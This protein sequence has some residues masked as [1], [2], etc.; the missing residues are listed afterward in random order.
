MHT[1]KTVFSQMYEHCVRNRYHTFVT[2]DSTELNLL[3]FP[4]VMSS[5]SAKA[6]HTDCIITFGVTHLWPKYKKIFW[7]KFD[8]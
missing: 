8:N 7:L 2:M 6:L 5:K 4:L 3:I 1:D